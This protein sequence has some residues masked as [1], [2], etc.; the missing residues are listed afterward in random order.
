M[1]L[2]AA[3][4]PVL[5]L[6]LIATT[7]S[8]AVA[9]PGRSLSTS[10]LIVSEAGVFAFDPN[11]LAIRWR[12]L[13]D[14]Q[15]L[16]PV[17]S[18]KRVYVTGSRGLYAIALDSG[19]MIWQRPSARGGFPPVLHGQQIYLA[20]RDG[21]LQAIDA[22]DGSL[23]WQRRFPG[24]VYP[25][26]YR[27]GLLFTGG[28]E[29][30]LWAVDIRD[31]AIR[32]SFPLGQELVYSPLALDGGQIIA[33]TFNR[34]V[35]SIDHQGEL[36]WRQRYGAIVS[37]PLALDGQLIFKG[38]DHQ[39]HAV[40]EKD[41]DV[42]WRR[43]LPERLAVDLQHRRGVLVASLESGRVWELDAYSGELQQEY[44]LPGE[45]IAAPQLVGEGVL[46]F[47]RAFDGPKAVFLNRSHNPKE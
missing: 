29:G 34:E 14:Q 2:S 22:A 9:A 5:C 24:W 32:W 15:T 37:D 12:Q 39:L 3:G 43:Q 42:L 28:S 40:D 1:L 33:T 6:W 35:L 44:R 30:Y 8:N 11:T 17:V 46:G 7:F 21:S 26:A 16:Q 31:G 38:L 10:P 4:L 20:S 36:L 19:E 13:R 47:I 27:E 23:L 25:P 18:D 45:P 41:G